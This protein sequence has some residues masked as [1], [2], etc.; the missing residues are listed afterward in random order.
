MKNVIKAYIYEKEIFVIDIYGNLYMTKGK[1]YDNPLTSLFYV[2]TEQLRL[3]KNNVK[4]I[5]SKM[6]DSAMILE[7]DGKLY[8]IGGVF[9]SMDKLILISENVKSIGG[10]R[11]FE[12]FYYIT[13]ENELYA[14]MEKGEFILIDKDVKMAHML[15]YDINA[16]EGERIVTSL[17]YLKYD[18]TLWNYKPNLIL[19]KFDNI[20]MSRE[21]FENH[22]FEIYR[23]K[24]PIL[25][26]VKTFNVTREYI[27]FTNN[28]NKI[29]ILPLNMFDPFFY[30]ISQLYNISTNNKEGL[31]YVYPYDIKPI[32]DKN[33]NII[34]IFSNDE[35]FSILD[36][37]NNIYYVNRNSN[38]YEFVASN[39]IAGHVL[40]GGKYE[41]LIV[42]S[43]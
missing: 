22:D 1:F 30:N 16:D 4:D 34:K 7:M 24:V 2:S 18:G 42:K 17:Y 29:R 10:L 15:D 13:Y 23:T 31:G 26:N 11:Y 6:S 5:A 38:K 25:K 33:I 14:M 20:E 41:W 28:N 21:E 32:I 19:N 39:V 36:E 43:D 37:N 3:V 40:A 27:A 12:F 9:N 8:G 35:N